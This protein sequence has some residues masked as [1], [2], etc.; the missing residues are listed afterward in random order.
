MTTIRE[1][2]TIV[3]FIKLKL[4][5]VSPRGKHVKRPRNNLLINM[6]TTLGSKVTRRN[7]QTDDM[8]H[9]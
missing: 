4:K 9:N 1:L 5:N 6:N 7:L 8:T 3:R 2:C